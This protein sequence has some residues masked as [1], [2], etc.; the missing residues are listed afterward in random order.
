MFKLLMVA[1]PLVAALVPGG[2]MIAS[3]ASIVSS[4]AAFLATPAGKWIGL[5]LIGAGLYAVGDLHRARID[6]AR[7]TA[8]WDAAVLRAETERAARDQAIRRDVSA[9]ADRRI[10]DIQRESDQLQAKVTDYERALSASNA[11]ACLV[12]A[13]D[14]RRLRELGFAPGPA[15]DRPPRGLRANSSGGRPAGRQG[16]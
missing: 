16:R 5:A 7:F 1:R 12:S 14:A 3:A 9:D 10:A 13:D 8:T 6:H 4:I 15:H 2:G 11:A